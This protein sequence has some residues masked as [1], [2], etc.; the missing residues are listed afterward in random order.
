MI[1][2]LL[3][4]SLLLC[5][6]ALAQPPQGSQDGPQGPGMGAPHDKFGPRGPRP[7]GEMHPMML[8][9]GRW[10]KDAEIVKNIGL[11]DGQVQKIEQIF[12]ESR[13]KLVDVHANLQKEEFKLEPLLEADNPDENAVLSAIDRITAARAT[14]EKA[15]AQM[16]FA[17]RR[18]LTPD[19]WKKLRALRPPRDHFP[20]P[21]PMRG[22]RAGVHQDGRS[23]EPPDSAAPNTEDAFAPAP[24]TPP[25]PDARK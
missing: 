14:L 18:V 15:N 24:D 7:G 2:K 22:P 25:A 6:V 3:I 5:T 8:P 23:P 11:N 13:M 12:Q 17:I 16:A 21:G 10:W 19:Q 20:S 1:R 4:A 9:P